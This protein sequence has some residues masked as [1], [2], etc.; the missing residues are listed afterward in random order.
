MSAPR[1]FVLVHGA[2][3]GG[4]CWDR[5][6][7]LLRRE[8]HRVF[9]PTLTGLA[10][11][12]HLMSHRIT[13]D[14][15][16]GDVVDV[17][18]RNDLE[19]AILVGHSFGGWAISGA[20]EELRNRV[21]VLIF[22]DAHVP[23]NGQIARDTSHHRDQIDRALREGRASTPPRADAAE[24]F[25][26]NERD[27]AWV[28]AKLTDQPVGVYLSP[29]HLTGARE[30]VQHKAY[31]RA[32]DFESGT[33]ERYRADA[34]RNGWRIYD[35]ACGHDIM[36]DDPVRLTAILQE[37]CDARSNNLGRTESC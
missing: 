18:R 22:V 27:R 3:H 11:R 25:K 34:E 33:F 20:V 15:H 7:E 29:I 28:Q 23:A 26:V 36:I 1:D 4:W 17:F 30:A 19:N 32:T 8:G 31:I 14:T 16:I 13:L 9:T 21:A 35:V 10:E 24:W 37:M 12:A 6:A 5:V 2:W